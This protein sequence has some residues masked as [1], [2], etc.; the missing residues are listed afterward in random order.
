[1]KA[2]M[3]M[4]DSLRKD[5]LPPYGN[6]QIIAPNFTR[7]AEQSVTFDNCY[8]GSMPCMPA[9]REMHTGR[10]NFLHRIWGPLEPFDDSMPELLK[11]HGIYTHLVTDHMHYWED[12]GCTY[13]TRYNTW[14]FIRGQEGDP[15]IGQVEDPKIPKHYGHRDEMPLWRQD[16]INQSQMPEEKQ[17]PT[18]RVFEDA[19]TF[20]KH[21]CRSDNWFLQIESF[22]P[23][24]PFWAPK[25]YRKLYSDHYE[26]PH[27]NWPDYAPVTE[28]ED[29]VQHCRNQYMALIT[30]CDEY[31]GRIL[32]LMDE[33]DLWKDTML[34]VNTD[35]GILLGEHGR[36]GKRVC[37]NYNEIA[38]IP[39]FIW[40]PRISKKDVHSNLLIQTIDLAPSLLEYF[41]VEIPKDMQGIL[42]SD[43]LKNKTKDREALL[44]GLFGAEV[45]CTDGRYVYMRAPVEQEN[46]LF[47]YTLMPTY[48]ASRFT[49]E[50]LADAKISPPFSFTKNCITLKI[51]PSPLPIKPF[52]NYETFKNRLYDLKTAPQ[53]EK[54][55]N[56]PKEEKR[57]IQLMTGLMKASDAPEEQ[58]LRLGL[59]K[60]NA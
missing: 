45:N 33:M 46:N 60:P 49:P 41:D 57:M 12:G 7:L 18:A 6:K 54:P 16:W 52:L 15:W 39:L 14:D 44:F 58:Y 43:R 21:N 32:N 3:V 48:I 4:F 53:Q 23:H 19:E 37:S 10:Y 27:F 42:I 34:I 38:N 1:M 51:K 26:G 11:N 22:T 59:E 9:R 47:N 50:E 28:D 40:D 24:E 55:I 2:I 31:L 20:I 29:A 35:H 13:H 17:T 8:I 5:M 25:K 30:M 56:N 36:W